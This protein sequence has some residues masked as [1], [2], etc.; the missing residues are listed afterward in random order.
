MLLKVFYRLDSVRFPPPPLSFQV[1]PSEGRRDAGGGAAAHSLPVEP[2]GAAEG[3][4]DGAAETGGL[5]QLVRGVEALRVFRALVGYG[6]G[7][8]VVI[9]PSITCRCERLQ[10]NTPSGQRNR[11]AT[12]WL[13]DFRR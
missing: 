10:Q 1:P 7:A 13:Y 9:T 5:E 2:S 3:S 4:G 6:V 12:Q 8:L 11:R